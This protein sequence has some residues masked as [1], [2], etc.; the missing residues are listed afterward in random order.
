MT[1]AG[2]WVSTLT[3]R[4]MKHLSLL[5]VT[6]LPSKAGLPQLKCLYTL[7]TRRNLKS[8]LPPTPPLISILLLFWQHRGSVSSE[9]S[10]S[11]PPWRGT[12]IQ[13]AVWCSRPPSSS[14]R[15]LLCFEAT[16]APSTAP[17]CRGSPTTTPALSKLWTCPQLHRTIMD[18]A[19]Q[20]Q[21]RGEAA[22]SLRT[23]RLEKNETETFEKYYFPQGE[24]QYHSFLCI[25]ISPDS[26]A[27]VHLS[28]T[29]Q[30][31]KE[32]PEGPSA[33]WRS[34]YSGYSWLFGT[35]ASFGKTTR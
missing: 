29:F 34:T 26:T 2:A 11:V 7:R 6:S 5:T 17:T 3:A 10:L 30:D 21:S 4:C 13:P 20:H 28:D 9:G 31:S 32:H 24:W 15:M 16:V 14:P 1:S 12:L 22:L 8:H 18:L 23:L 27:D 35:R 33:C 19:V 25:S